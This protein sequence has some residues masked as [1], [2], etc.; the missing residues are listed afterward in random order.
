MKKL[1]GLLGTI[2]IT[3]NTIPSVIA[4]SPYQKEENIKNSDINYRQTNNLETL[5]RNKRGVDDGN[6]LVGLNPFYASFVPNLWEEIIIIKYEAGNNLSLFREKVMKKF[7]VYKFDI[8][9][10][11]I[12]DSVVYNFLEVIFNNWDYVNFYWRNS[13]KRERIRIVTEKNMIAS[14][15]I[16]TGD[17]K[18]Y[19][20][21]YLN[22]QII[23]EVLINRDLGKL[24]IIN[25]QTILNS[26]KLRNWNIDISH[27]SV[28][29]ITNKSAK[30]TVS[31]I[32]KY[33][34][35]TWVNVYFKKHD[36]ISLSG[37][38]NNKIEILNRNETAILNELNY[39]N[40][41]LDI[42][43]LELY[44]IINTSAIIKAK[45]DNS[46]Y[47]DEKKIYFTINN[48]ENKIIDLGELIKKGIFLSFRDKNKESIIK[49][50]NN[51]DENDLIYSNIKLTKDINEIYN[52]N[53]KELCN[54]ITM[55]TNDSSEIQNMKTNSCTYK[56][57][58]LENIKI[59]VGL[60][61]RKISSQTSKT[62]QNSNLELNADITAKNKYLKKIL[63]LTFNAE[64]KYQNETN[65]E[66]S[67]IQ[68]LS[69]EFDL[70]DNKEYE[71]KETS[72]ITIP[73]QEIKVNPRQ[74]IKFSI[75]LD[76]VSKQIIWNLKQNIHGEI[77]AEITNEENM[78]Y[79][80]EISIKEI[81]QKLK[82]YSL[83]PQEITINNDDTITFNGKLMGSLQQT[84]NNKI[85]IEQIN[86]Y[87]VL[88]DGSC[89]FWSVATAYLLPVRN[90]ND[91]FRA[92]FIHLFSIENIKNLG[93]IQ[94]L[95]RE[96]DLE[97]HNN[98]Q[99]WYQNQTA[100]N[101][102]TNVFR[103]RVVDYI[104]SNLNMITNRGSELTFRTII[105]S[106]NE[107]ANNYLNR[108]RQSSTW[109]GT[110]EILAMSNMLNANISVNNHAPYQPFNQ[111]SNNTINIFHVNGNHYNFGLSNQTPQTDA[112]YKKSTGG[113]CLTEEDNDIENNSL[114]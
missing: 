9:N 62:K 100:N 39:L 83:L 32:G 94:N 91:E 51:I 102:V 31:S 92:R 36:L 26:I 22:N 11:F 60:K 71:N 105:E 75:L 16:R 89:L 58:K 114:F 61:N 29:D 50:I 72:E 28:S 46:K 109:G 35:G 69:D 55:L 80:F 81:M 37:I 41:D 33:N 57:E 15:V 30:I 74:K 65:F 79:K 56:K 67:K 106:N 27:L 98:N 96:Y 90:N 10:W 97:N 14:V 112:E 2:M 113:G 93:D 86:N 5:N 103:N 3:G 40:Y 84:L 110:P 88:A 47:F 54:D 107:I 78:T 44:D 45:K 59:T 13:T 85:K 108:M 99:L 4:A 95:L 87:D 8:W 104:Q 25:Q 38:K 101:L 17:S 21:D 111:N 6:E 48:Q 34:K 70:S 76:Q 1:L 68:E 43:Q 64:G 73:S 63:G 12:T 49:E 42:S 53:T 77:N 19:R 20:N 24:F 23:N 52:K 18:Y 66:D 7:K 82:Q